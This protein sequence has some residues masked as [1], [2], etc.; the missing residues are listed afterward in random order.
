MLCENYVVEWE[1]L[2]QKREKRGSSNDLEQISGREL[3]GLVFDRKRKNSFNIV[4]GK[5]KRWMQ[6]LIE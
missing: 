2:I 4:H 5:R 6:M 1:R 3:K